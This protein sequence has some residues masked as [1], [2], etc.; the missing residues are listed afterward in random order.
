MWLSGLFSPHAFLS[1]ILQEHARVVGG[2]IDS[3]A[4]THQLLSEEE[5][6]QVGGEGVGG[7]VIVTGLW[8]EGARWDDGERRLVECS[9]DSA[10]SP[11]PWIHFRPAVRE[12]RVERAVD[13]LLGGMGDEEEV[14]MYDCP[15]YE[16]SGRSVSVCSVRVPVGGE[17]LGVNHWIQRGVALLMQLDN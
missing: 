11:S 14:G 7:G 17:G 3:I 12:G 13:D 9:E 10:V 4:F 5:T 6:Q 16:T 1:A 2:C 8:L 15:L